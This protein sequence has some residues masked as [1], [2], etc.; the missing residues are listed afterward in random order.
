RY[1][2]ELVDAVGAVREADAAGA[3]IGEVAPRLP[4]QPRVQCGRV[5]LE[6]EDGP[7]RREVGTVARGVP[8]GA[9]GELVALEQHG[10]GPAPPGEM[11]ERAAADDS[12][13]D[14]HDPRGALQHFTRAPAGA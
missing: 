1:V 5:L 2:P 3:V 12:P 11:I 10:V 9:G 14:D 6:L 4:R 13:A 7:A 8:G